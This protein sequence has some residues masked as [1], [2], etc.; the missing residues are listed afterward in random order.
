MS[1][2]ERA[3]LHSRNMTEAGIA[4]LKYENMPV[5]YVEAFLSCFNGQEFELSDAAHK[6]CLKV[7]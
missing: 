4:D 5:I 6:E 1:V 7:A 3:T 2:E